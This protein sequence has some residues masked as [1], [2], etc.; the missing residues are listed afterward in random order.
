MQEGHDDGSEMG[1]CLQ[2]NGLMA[3]FSLSVACYV[4]LIQEVPVDE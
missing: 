1:Y 2:E 4:I 3:A